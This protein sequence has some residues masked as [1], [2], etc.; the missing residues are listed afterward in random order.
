M[1]QN[2][3]SNVNTKFYGQD[4]GYNDNT[5]KVEFKSGR[6]VHYLRNSLPRKTH[7]LM[8]RC[9]DKGTAKISGKTEFEW[10]LYWYENT[11]KSGALT[12]Y[13]TDVITGS[14]TKEYRFTE[15]PSWN[16]QRYKEISLSIEEV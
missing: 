2:W 5:E 14:G 6:T 9:K 16:G 4:G 15:T 11:V 8:L 10:F 7:S 12:F 3:N 13:L 1:A